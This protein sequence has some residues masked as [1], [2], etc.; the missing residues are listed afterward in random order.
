MK[1]GRMEWRKGKY[2][3][4]KN[5]ILAIKSKQVLIY[6]ITWK[7]LENVM[8]VKEIRYKRPH[9]INPFVWNIQNK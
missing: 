5:K 4:L 8:L 9:I 2:Q 3:N 7:I 1:R 6:A